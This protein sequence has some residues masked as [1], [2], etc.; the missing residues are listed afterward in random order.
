MR[1]KIFSSL[2][3]VLAF[4]AMSFS[5]GNDPLEIGK[6]SPAFRELTTNMD[7]KD[8]VLREYL[9][10]NGIMVIFSSNT[11]PFV[12]AWESRYFGLAEYCEA[13][14]IGFV[15][16]NSNEANRN[17]EDSFINMKNHAIDKG[18]KFPYVMDHN[19]TIADAFGAKSTPHVYF[20][21][22]SMKLVYRG[23]IDD[24]YK[25]ESK[26]TKTYA[27]N[28]MR[29]YMAGSPAS[30]AITDALGCSIKRVK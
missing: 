28:A 23:A 19:S 24:N 15:L 21:D 9:K 13:N 14:N 17:D 10:L 11:C 20:F 29:N 3:V 16:I 25:D 27:L 8:A 6:S 12:K 4:V 7:G 22:N 5:T 26:V 2:I 18:Y 1:A 30:P